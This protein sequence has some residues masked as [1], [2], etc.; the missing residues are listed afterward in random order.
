[1]RRFI[2]SMVLVALTIGCTDDVIRH[3]KTDFFFRASTEDETITAGC[4]NPATAQ[5]MVVYTDYNNNGQMD[6]EAEQATA[7][8]RD[9]LCGGVD[10]QD[11]QDGEDG[12]NVLVSI[13][14][15]KACSSSGNY[16]AFYLDTNRNGIAE[17]TLDDFLGGYNVCDGIDGID[18][19]SLVSDIRVEG[20]CTVVDLYLDMDRSGTVSELDIPQSSFTVCNGSDGADG[21]DAPYLLVSNE[22]IAPLEQELTFYLDVDGSFSF[23]TGDLVVERIVVR[24]GE[25]GVQGIQGP[26]GER[27]EAGADGTNG[28][29]GTDGLDGVSPPAMG[30]YT[31]YIAGVN[32]FT[33][34]Y[35]LNDDGDFDETDEIASTG[36][37]AD[38]QDGADG[39]TGDTGADGADG[40]NWLFTTEEIMANP[41]CSAEQEVRLDYFGGDDQTRIT[42]IKWI[43]TEEGIQAKWRVRNGQDVAVTNVSVQVGGNPAF[44]TASSIAAN[45]EVFFLTENAYNGASVKWDGGSKGTASSG[46]KPTEAE[47]ACEGG[48]FL[49]GG[50]DVDRNG[51]LTDNEKT[52]SQLLPSGQDGADGQDGQDLIGS[53]TEYV[54]PLPG[55]PSVMGGH[56]ELV[57]KVT[58]VDGNVRYFGVYYDKGKKRTFLSELFPGKTYATT[59]GRKGTFKVDNL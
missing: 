5:T 9:V 48:L 30:V 12:Y 36:S 13:T 8:P 50:L 7:V 45:T 40:Y 24:D 58:D 25:Q 16:V 39:A 42:F 41:Y 35:D 20:T 3:E 46:D 57:M 34:Y 56:K 1:M 54:D 22:R 10:G 17:P 29:D 18:A 27:G 19:F 26:Q 44:F 52:L 21:A 11:G 14:S 43:E 32:Y 47:T 55:V 53:T 49:F 38:G 31:E 51:E 28:V 6:T 15:S 37:I 59:D 23:N 4:D 33:F 2:F